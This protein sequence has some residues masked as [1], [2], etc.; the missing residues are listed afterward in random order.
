MKIYRQT[1]L[2]PSTVVKVTTN[3]WPEYVREQERQHAQRL[4]EDLREAGLVIKEK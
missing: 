3:T 1:L 4:A 2:D